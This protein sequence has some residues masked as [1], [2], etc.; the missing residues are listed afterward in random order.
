MRRYKKTDLLELILSLEKTND[1]IRRASTEKRLSMLGELE[2]CQQT[3]IEVGTA[4]EERKE[5]GTRQ[6]VTLLEAYCE[7]IYRMGT[8]LYD[9]A[10]CGKLV[11]KI[12]KLLPEISNKIRYELSEDKKEVV[13]LPYKASMWDS[14]ESV[15]LAARED[16]DCDAYVVPIPYFDKNAD[17]TMGKMYY[18]G[19]EFPENIPITSW[20]EYLIPERKPDIIFIHNPYDEYNYVT[21]V[22]PAFYAK[23]LKKYTN[24]L[25]YIPYFIL[26]EIE[27][28]DQARIDGMKHFITEP[29]VI[30]ADKVI[31]QSEKMKQIYVNEYIKWA[32]EQGLTGKH[33]DRKYQESRILGLGS[34]KVDKILRTR[35]EDLKIPEAWLR[36]IR[37]ADGS[38]KKVVFYNTGVTAMLHYNEVWVEKIEDVL[39]LFKENQDEVVLLWRPHPLIENTMKSMRPELLVKY[40]EIKNQYIDEGWGIYDDTSDVDRAVVLSDA[41]YGDGSSVVQMYQKTGKP[42]M[43][44][45]H[46]YLNASKCSMA[47]QN[48]VH[49]KGMNWLINAK[50]NGIYKVN[51]DSLEAELVDII[52]WE[53]DK[54]EHLEVYG[55]VVLYKAKLFFIP[56]SA[57]K[58]CLFDIKKNELRYIDYGNKQKT[59]KGQIFGGS[60]QRGRILYL[61]PCAFD[62]V[63]CVDMENEQAR[64]VGESLPERNLVYAFGGIFEDMEN[65]Y[66][67]SIN[68]NHIFQY[69]L[70]TEEY[71]TYICEE[72]KSGGS[73]MIGDANG[74]WIIPVKADKIL[75]WDRNDKVVK[76]YTEFPEG[77]ESGEWSFS[78]VSQISDYIVLFPREANMCIFVNKADG[79]MERFD[80][81]GIC[82]QK[83][84]S[85]F[86][87][88][89]PF[90]CLTEWKDKILIFDNVTGTV[91]EISAGGKTVRKR[92]FKMI[93]RKELEAMNGHEIIYEKEGG[94]V[95]LERLLQSL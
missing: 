23:N 48:S 66:F 4:L 39:R 49:Y 15:Y 82:V 75:F 16:E 35:K 34:P 38:W 33:I 63:V 76:K 77:Y 29:G 72:L 24:E 41:Y 91:F 55:E 11:K 60:V 31:V 54:K 12:Q 83:R 80:P 74:V 2:K 89:K 7:D 57:S 21:S 78:K 9:A 42:V 25:V 45:D 85:Y 71:K 37:K 43:I 30:W 88:Y 59:F 68:S 73:G 47:I 53:A 44:Q 79:H 87:K 81:D 36:V 84:V 51:M 86:H 10:E 28:D 8:A 62:Y 40:L 20:Q 70:E 13:F 26:G 5:T 27:P 92:Q 94:I 14:L 22:H 6:I 56:I 17:G 32:K 50:D 93:N 58:I 1:K 90:S 61:I 46:V 18:E 19:G 64:Y 95:N 67:T 3:A 69:N 52:P 65:I